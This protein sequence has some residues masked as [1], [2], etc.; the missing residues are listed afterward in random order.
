VLRHR[1]LEEL[2]GAPPGVDARLLVGL[3]APSLVIE[4]AGQPLDGQT[5]V[6]HRGGRV[7]HVNEVAGALVLE[8]A[9]WEWMAVS[10]EA[11]ECDVGQIRG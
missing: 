1:L 8:V 9:I 6:A 4:I 10:L 3:R 11:P 2:E 5:D 7:R